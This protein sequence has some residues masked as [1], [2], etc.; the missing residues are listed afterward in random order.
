MDTQIEFLVRGEHGDTTAALREY[1]L[2]RRTF[3]VRRFEHH[4]A[5]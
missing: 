3:A 2:R 1:A 4:V 5:R